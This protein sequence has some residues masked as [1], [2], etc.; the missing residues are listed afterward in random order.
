MIATGLA[1]LGLSLQWTLW[2]QVERPAY[3]S[4]S[5]EIP[6]KS[7]QSVGTVALLLSVD[8]APFR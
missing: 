2:S 3:T 5:T 8:F 4:A 6:A 1:S 7:D